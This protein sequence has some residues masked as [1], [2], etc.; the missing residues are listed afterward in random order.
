MPSRPPDFLE[1]VVLATGSYALLRR[2]SSPEAAVFLAEEDAL[3]LHHPGIREQQRRIVG[4]HERG[5]GQNLVSILPEEF[6]ESTT[7]FGGLHRRISVPLE[8]QQGDR[9]M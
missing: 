9:S 1:V 7:D 2:G 8:P 5:A 4:G 6:Q 3:E